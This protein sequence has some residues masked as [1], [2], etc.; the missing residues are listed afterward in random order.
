MITEASQHICRL[1]ETPA[2]DL[3]HLDSATAV[4]PLLA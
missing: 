2:V 1:E 4:Y 3:H